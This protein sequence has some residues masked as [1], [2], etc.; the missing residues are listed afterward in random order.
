MALINCKEC[1]AEVIDK[2]LDCLKCGARLRKPKRT[3]LESCLKIHL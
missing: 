1:G 3:F 2:A